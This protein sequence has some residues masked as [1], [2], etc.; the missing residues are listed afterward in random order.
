MNLV[1]RKTIRLK[2]DEFLKVATEYN[3]KNDTQIAAAIGV[4]ATTLWRVKLP[5]DDERHNSPGTTLI[6]GIMTAF[7]SPFERFFFL[8]N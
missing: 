4:T 7:N 2:K 1:E 5:I 8:D 3:L 6:A